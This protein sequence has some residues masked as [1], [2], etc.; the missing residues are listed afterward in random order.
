[1]K[2][3]LSMFLILIL[4]LSMA[5]PVYADGIIGE[6]ETE[7][8]IRGL[9][10][11]NV[12]MLVSRYFTQRKA[13]LQRVSDTINA[14]HERRFTN[15]LLHR[16]ALEEVDAQLVDSTIVIDAVGVGEHTA[17]V[18][19]TETVSMLINGEVKQEIVFH[20]VL[21][22]LM[23]DSTLL[24]RGDGYFEETIGFASASYRDPAMAPDVYGYSIDATGSALCIIAIARTQLG[25]TEG[26]NNYTKYGVWLTEYLSDGKVYSDQP[27]CAAFVSWC[28]YHANVPD[29]VIHRTGW[30]PTMRDEF[31]YDGLLTSPASYTPQAGDI[32]FFN[33][34][35]YDPWHVGI[36]TGVS[37]A[38]IYYIDGN[39]ESTGNVQYTYISK[40]AEAIVA[41]GKSAYATTN[42]TYGDLIYDASGHWSCCQNCGARST[43]TAHSYIGAWQ[44]DEL[45]HWRNC[46]N[47]EVGSLKIAHTMLW[48]VDHYECVDCGRIGDDDSII[49]NNDQTENSEEG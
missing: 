6:M 17:E 27:W 26:A 5:A 24:V 46:Q 43:K 15:E 4:L 13:F 33:G 44:H 19:V 10:E 37:G 25:Y 1:M 49:I 34:D 22:E 45:G 35:Y 11:F 47:C 32:I 8:E 42:H 29:S 12:R 3:Y 23:P 20:E 2:R 21:V 18:F 41:Y 38:Y 36:V 16:T 31:Y 39:S 40:Y 14:A 30:V 7:V 9:T 48:A 28:A